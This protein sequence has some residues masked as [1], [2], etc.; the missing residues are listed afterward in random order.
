MEKLGNKLA[1]ELEG[2]EK[3]QITLRC[4]PLAIGWIGKLF[5]EIWKAFF[6]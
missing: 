5:T 2:V 6:Y 4:F 3:C 1:V